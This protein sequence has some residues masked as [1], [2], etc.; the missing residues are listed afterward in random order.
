LGV[1]DRRTVE[2]VVLVRRAGEQTPQLTGA[3]KPGL[4]GLLPGP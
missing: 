4:V 1:R 2:N 3:S